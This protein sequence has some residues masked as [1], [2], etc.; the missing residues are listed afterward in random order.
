ML[1]IQIITHAPKYK[2][3]L[4]LMLLPTAVLPVAVHAGDMAGATVGTYIITRALKYNMPKRL[5]LR[6]MANQ[7]IDT[8]VGVIPFLGDIFDFGFKVGAGRHLMTAVQ[9]GCLLPSQSFYF[10]LDPRADFAG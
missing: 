7:A 4:F 3:H 10:F 1:G 2:M 8:C 5:V 9:C 6:M